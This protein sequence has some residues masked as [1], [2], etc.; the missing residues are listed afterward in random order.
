MGHEIGP[1]ALRDLVEWL[2]AKVLSP[3][4]LVV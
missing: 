1:E 4:Q 3:I 2:D